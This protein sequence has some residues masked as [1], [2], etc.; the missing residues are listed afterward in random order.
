MNSRK[1]QILKIGIVG[2]LFSILV[3]LSIKIAN[4]MSERVATEKRI[5]QPAELKAKS[6]TNSNL[7][8]NNQE[9]TSVICFFDADCHFC[10]TELKQIKIYLDSIPL[11]ESWTFIS[12]DNPS[13]ILE[14]INGWDVYWHSRFVS[15]SIGQMFNYFGVKTVPQIF[16]YDNRGILVH[17]TSGIVKMDSLI[18]YF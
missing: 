7:K 12:R 6:I 16:V 3:T 9:G 13:K 1:K 14:K 17:K 5:T 8:I 10:E 4:A 2:L 11:R 18:K 15:D